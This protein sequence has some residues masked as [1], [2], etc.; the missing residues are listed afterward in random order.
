MR[1]Q[2]FFYLCLIVNL[3]CNNSK[4]SFNEIRG[5]DISQ[6]D[7]HLI[8]SLKDSQG[9][10]SI[11]R[12]NFFSKKD[13]IL[14]SAKE[15]EFYTNPKFSPDGEK[16]VFIRYDKKDLKTSSLCISENDGKTYEYLI[17]DTGIITEAIFSKDGDQ[18]FFLMA[19]TFESF[20]PIGIA[21]THNFD[22]YSYNFI[23][24]EIIKLSNIDA[25]KLEYLSL[26]D[27]NNLMLFKYEGTN[28]GM[29]LYN[30]DQKIITE[31]VVPENN[32]RGDASLYYHPVYSDSFQQLAFI[33]PYQIYV[34]NWNTKFAELVFDNR[35]HEQINH[36]D[37]FHKKNKLLFVKKNTSDFYLIDLEKNSSIQLNL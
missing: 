6:N 31:R 18:L 19:K 9:N 17:K 35:G 30:L 24:E 16:F 36:I 28:G 21:D 34:M 4:Q 37:F 27:K 15:N 12:Y 1:F 8:Y 3:S 5:F 29:F 25:Y 11:K 32:P 23:T 22:I 26:F 10:T 14:I 2:L 33:A 13:T 20:S 7:E